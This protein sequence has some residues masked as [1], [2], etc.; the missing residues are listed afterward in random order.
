MIQAGRET[1]GSVI[2][3]LIIISW[4]ITAVNFIQNHIEYS[5]LNVEFKHKS[6]CKI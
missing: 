6:N 2:H 3:K 5:S 1:L 4:D